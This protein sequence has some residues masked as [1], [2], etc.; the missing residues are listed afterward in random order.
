MGKLTFKDLKKQGVLLTKE[1][2]MQL[3]H[4]INEI[5][6]RGDDGLN[7]LFPKKDFGTMGQANNVQPSKGISAK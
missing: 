2:A 7:D 6:Q 3:H 1:E 4:Q 5:A